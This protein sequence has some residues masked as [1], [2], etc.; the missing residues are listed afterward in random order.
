MDQR[1][2]GPDGPKVSS[3]GYGAM[4]FS[5]MYGPTNAEESFAI[6]D[7]CLDAGVDHLDTSNVYGMGRSEEVIGRYLS[8]YNDRGRLP[9]KIATKGGITKDGNGKRTFDNSREHL[10]AELDKSLERLGV[11]EVELYYVHR[12]DPSLEIEEVTE[13]LASFVK[14]GKVRA[15]GFSEIAPTSLKRAAAMHPIAAVQSEYSLSTRL[16]ELG[17]IRACEELG[18]ALVAFSPV[19]RALLSDRPPTVERAAASP[20]LSANPRFTGDNLR[21]NIAA[22][23][24]LRALAREM[25]VATASLAIAW[26]LAQSRVVIPIPGTRSVRH[27]GE[28]VAGAGMTLDQATLAEIERRLPPGWAHGERYGPSQ[29]GAE[30]YC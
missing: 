15:I 17:L 22:S 18:T 19:G 10:E 11:D 20:F 4:S 26:L 28:L 25:G 3:L 13:T 24:P 7:A 9:F 8:R 2:L 14:A 1:M 5:D 30:N 12:R 27:L 16:P 23:E 29:T 21:R 6:M